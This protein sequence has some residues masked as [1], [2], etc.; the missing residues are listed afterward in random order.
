M[1]TALSGPEM[2]PLVWVGAYS[3]FSLDHYARLAP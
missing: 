1:S 3:S 2:T